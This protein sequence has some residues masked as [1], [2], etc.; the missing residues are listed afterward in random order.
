MRDMETM[1]YIEEERCGARREAPSLEL[2]DPGAFPP[3]I[4]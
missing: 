4:T 2:R 1:G 3:G